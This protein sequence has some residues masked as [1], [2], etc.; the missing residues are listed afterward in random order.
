MDL[1]TEALS[2]METGCDDSSSSSSLASRDSDLE[3]CCGSEPRNAS[4]EDDNDDSFQQGQPDPASTSSKR[5]R[6]DGSQDICR[7]RSPS[8]TAS[9]RW[10][11]SLIIFDWDDTLLPSTW[12][13]QQGLSII[14]GSAPPTLEQ[15]T[16]LR[17]VAR[18]VRRILQ[19]AKRYGIAIIVTNAEKGWVELTCQKFLPS[20]C[21]LLE[22]TK[23]VSARSS[24][25]HLLQPQSPSLWKCLVFQKEVAAMEEMKTHFSEAGCCSNV[26][27][28]GDSKFERAA[29]FEATQGL[30]C[31]TKSLKLMERPSLEQL[32]KQQ[33]LLC[34]CLRPFV[35]FEG[36]LDLG[37][38][39]SGQCSSL[40]NCEAADHMQQQA[41]L[42]S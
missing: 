12:L 8:V 2:D 26:V 16:S 31:W 29:V 3:P 23:V 17:R 33:D 4:G 18:R 27:S 38:Q 28:I 1:A 21:P 15:S 6:L 19:R 13:Q 41:A 14:P 5:R 39:I 30:K 20:I 7:G 32:V 11:S 9:L 25:P 22:G 40:S 24:F 37:M 10:S 36:S 35:E 42:H 34:A